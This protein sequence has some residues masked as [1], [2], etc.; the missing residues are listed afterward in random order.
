MS[1][2]WESLSVIRSSPPAYG[3]CNKPTCKA[4]IEWVTTT[5]K[6]AKIPVDLPLAIDRVYERQDGTHVTV[7]DQRAV[8]WTTCTESRER[9]AAARRTDR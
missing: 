2:K 1:Q 5:G 4:A 7:I 8:H 3:V 6:G 9:V